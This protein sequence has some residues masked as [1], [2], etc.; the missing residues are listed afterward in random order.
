M[1]SLRERI[2]ALH[3]LKKSVYVLAYVLITSK[4]LKSVRKALRKV[5]VNKTLPQP[6][7]DK[8]QAPVNLLVQP[9]VENNGHDVPRE[10][11]LPETEKQWQVQVAC[12]RV[13]QYAERLRQ[14]LESHHLGARIIVKDNSQCPYRV[15]LVQIKFSKDEAQQQ[16]HLLQ[17]KLNLK[18][19]RRKID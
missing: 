8:Q 17:K 19:F 9:G 4:K 14:R 12:F 16:L 13:S 6:G 1:L 10:A 2:H 3:N 11:P 7:E 15:V 18:G 5:P